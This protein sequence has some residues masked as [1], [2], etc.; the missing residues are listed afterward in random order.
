MQ[1]ETDT[2][3]AA[4]HAGKVS[5][6]PLHFD[7]TDLAGIDALAGADLAALLAP[8]AREVERS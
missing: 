3:L 5:V 7:L 2:D 6:T 8:A 4:I 1:D